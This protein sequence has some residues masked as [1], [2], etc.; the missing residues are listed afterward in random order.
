[1]GILICSIFEKLVIYSCAIS[2]FFSIEEN[3]SEVKR[4][5]SELMKLD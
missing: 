4:N 1:M 2:M 5:K 3:L